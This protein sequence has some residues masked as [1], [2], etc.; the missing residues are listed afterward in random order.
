MAFEVNYN[1]VA[2][3]FAVFVCVSLLVYGAYNTY[4]LNYGNTGKNENQP[5]I[6]Y[7]HNL[8]KLKRNGNFHAEFYR[9]GHGTNGFQLKPK[10]K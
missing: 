4:A 3:W 8:L 10:A 7:A 9:Y 6:I 2:I 1:G 5:R